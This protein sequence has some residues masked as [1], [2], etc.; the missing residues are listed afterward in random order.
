MVFRPK[1]A[2]FVL[3]L[4]TAGLSGCFGSESEGG[5]PTAA[6]NVTPLTDGLTFRFDATNSSDPQGDALNVAWNFGDEGEQLG[7][8]EEFGL[9]DYTY[10]VTNTMFHVSLV[11][12][13]AQGNAG[14]HM[15]QVSIGTGVNNPPVGVVKN[16]TR[17][18]KPGGGVVLDASQSTDPDDDL[19]N[20]EW[21]MG[22]F[23]EENVTIASPFLQ[24]GQGYETTFEKVGVY[25]FHCHPHP[26]MKMRVVVDEADANASDF[27]EVD[28]TNYAYSDKVVTVRPGGTVNWTNRDPDVH[29]ATGEWFNGGKVISTSPIMSAKLEAGD[30]QARLILNDGKGGMTMKTYGL[31]ASTDAPDSPKTS[32]ILRNDL[33][34]VPTVPDQAY[35]GEEIPY[36]ADWPLN[37]TATV[38]WED[39][40]GG[41]IFRIALKQGV[42]LTNC[43]PEGNSCTLMYNLIPGTPYRIVLS[44]TPEG[45]SVNQDVVIDTS[46]IQWSYPPFGNSE[47]CPPGLDMHN[48]VCMKH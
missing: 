18:V 6:F 45:R 1:V 39:P 15:E 44:A 41:S 38:S 3:F 48:G 46:A 36:T 31:K 11:V 21:I 24:Q 32:Q 42:V 28:I 10:A 5:A 23:S 29:T 35:D 22:N 47:G 2:V 9:I 12:T 13:D 33:N 26:W 8:L 25:S 30:Y 16:A 27:A 40:S 43:V 20:Y 4:V 19:F 37:L 34:H 14:S 7:T 17:W